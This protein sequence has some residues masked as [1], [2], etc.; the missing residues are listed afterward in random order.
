ML[1]RCPRLVALARPA[2]PAAP[3]RL[4]ATSPRPLQRLHFP[5]TD[6][7]ASSPF[8]DVQTG[9]TRTLLPTFSD[10]H[11]EQTYK[12]EQLALVFRIL[13]RFKLAEGIAGAFGPGDDA[14]TR[15]RS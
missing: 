6:D 1:R 5:H 14:P 4:F 3:R 10:V 7:I 2:T 9:P 11:A 13:H 12:K 15:D 8:A